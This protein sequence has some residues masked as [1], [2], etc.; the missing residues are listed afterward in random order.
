MRLAIAA[1]R[2]YDPA[3][4]DLF[5]EHGGGWFAR[6]AEIEPWDAVLAL[7]PE[8]HRMLAGAELDDALTVVADFID[9]KSPYMAGHSRRCADLAADA[10][11]VLGLDDDAVDSAPPRGARPRLRH[12]GSSRTRSGT[13]PARSRARSS[14]GSSCIRC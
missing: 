2:T 13:S 4:A 10:A 14:T 7:E 1:T 8:P 9:L 12:D 5:I 11:Q 6:L 3:L